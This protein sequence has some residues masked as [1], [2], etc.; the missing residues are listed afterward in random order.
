[1]WTGE[2]GW[3]GNEVWTGEEGWT[4]NEVWTGKEGWTGNEVWT[5]EEGWTGMRCGLGVRCLFLSVGN[6]LSV[7]ST[8]CVAGRLVW[9]RREQ[10]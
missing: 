5:G 9:W 1:M 3:T 4:E 10:Q 8:P 7:S 6:V 2:E